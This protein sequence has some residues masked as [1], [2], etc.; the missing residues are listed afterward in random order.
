MQLSLDSS[1]E[2][3][4][5]NFV[6]FIVRIDFPL[7]AFSTPF[8]S[9]RF[10]QYNLILNI[11][12]IHTHTLIEVQFRLYLDFNR[13]FLTVTKKLDFPIDGEYQFVFI[14]KQYTVIVVSLVVKSSNTKKYSLII[15]LRLYHEIEFAD[16]S[17]ICLFQIDLNLQLWQQKP[18]I[19]K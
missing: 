10:R 5:S 13:L 4:G 1:K 16:E 6:T 9:A 18:S 2:N 3:K 11:F 14:W 12:E 8:C 15:Y 19:H 7:Y 17:V